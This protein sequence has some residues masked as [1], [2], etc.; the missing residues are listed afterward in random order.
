VAARTAP[1]FVELNATL[2]GAALFTTRAAARAKALCAQLGAQ[3]S[4]LCTVTFYANLAH[5]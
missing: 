4:F 5:S 2:T 1:S 3:A